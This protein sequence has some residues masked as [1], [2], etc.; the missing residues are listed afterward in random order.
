MVAT[1]TDP[2]VVDKPDWLNG[3][4]AKYWIEN[5]RRHIGPGSYPV[6]HGGLYPIITLYYYFLVFYLHCLENTK[7][8]TPQRMTCK[9]SHVLIL[10]RY[11]VPVLQQMGCDHQLHFLPNGQSVNLTLHLPFAFGYYFNATEFTASFVTEGNCFTCTNCQY[12]HLLPQLLLLLL[13]Q[14]QPYKEVL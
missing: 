8:R 11:K 12:H 7:V 4:S 2:Q 10:F 3:L 6:V 9:Y 13:L 1:E 5:F 14:L